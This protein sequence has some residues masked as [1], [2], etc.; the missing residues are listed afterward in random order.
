MTDLSQLP[1]ID[2]RSEEEFLNRHLK[3]SVNI[4]ASQLFMR[5]QELPKKE[6]AL[7]LVISDSER[8]AVL[9]FFSQ[10]SFN[11]VDVLV[12]QSLASDSSWEFES[13]RSDSYFWRPAPFVE[14]CYQHYFRKQLSPSAKVLDIAC[15]S[16]RDAI[17]LAMQ[18]YQVTAVDYSATALERCKLTASHHHVQL[19]L[20][21]CDLENSGWQASLGDTQ[22]FFDLIVVC[23]YL[24]RPLLP[25]LKRLIA[26]EGYILYQTFMRGAERIGSP[27]N[28]RFLLQPGEL[29]SCFSDFE[30]L[31]DDVELLADGRPMSRFLARRIKRN[32]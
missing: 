24:H 5:M 22:T 8:A 18:S 15:G 13:G 7:R 30:I 23:R 25:E 11:V 16:G 14:Y 27:K 6:T 31:M 3:G 21:Q 17:Y 1:I 28:P 29:A 32:D 12:W 2:T 26:P 19:K 9:D 4:P 10:R 20:V